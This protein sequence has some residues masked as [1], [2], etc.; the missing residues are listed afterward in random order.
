MFGLSF[1]EVLIIMVVALLVL[2]PDRLPKVAKNLGK[3]MR[4]FRRATGGF[5][6]VLE[7]ELYLED[8]PTEAPRPAAKPSAPSDGPTPVPRQAP[9]LL[10]AT[11]SV[12]DASDDA[13]ASA[14]EPAA[15]APPSVAL[16]DEPARAV[17]D[18]SADTAPRKVGGE[19]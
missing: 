17:S 5:R 8:D 11:A 12:P 3:G 10:P 13:D 16:G 6:Q 2:G 7:E 15:A 9:G 18:D 1:G 4:E 14:E 19:G